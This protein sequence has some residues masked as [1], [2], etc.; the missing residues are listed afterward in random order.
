MK[1]HL[2]LGTLTV[3]LLAITIS[4]S[5]HKPFDFDSVAELAHKTA[6]E[7]SQVKLST[8]P[9]ILQSLDYD[10]YRDIRWQEDKTLWKEQGM[11]FQIKFFHPGHIYREKVNIY[12]LNSDG[13]QEYPY[14]ATNFNFGKNTF[15]TDFPPDTGY[16]GFRIHYP[17]NSDKYLDE[18]AVF[19]G[20]S[21]F[22]AVGKGQ[23]YGQ[24]ARG[25]AIDTGLANTIEEFPVFTKFW[26]SE[27]TPN[28]NEFTMYALLES[29][30]VT[31]AYQFKIRPDRETRMH[32]KARLYFRNEVK[33]LGIAPLTSM[34]WFAENSREK[35]GDFRPEVHDTDG[36]LMKT[37]TGEW[38]WRPLDN[39]KYLQENSFADNK[40]Q[41]FGL[42]Q[43]DRD[44]DHYKDL[45]ARYH[46][47]PSTWVE[48]IRGFD[49]GSVQLVQ[50]S[51]K[52]EFM[53]N[54]VAFWVPDHKPKAGETMEFEYY[55]DWFLT[56][57][58]RPGLGYCR[59]TG[60]DYQRTPD[61]IMFVL[62][63]AGGKL[64]SIPATEKLNEV[65][66]TRPAGLVQNAHVIKNEYS[67]SPSWRL[68]FE[69]VSPPEGREV[70]I[71]ANLFKG[72]DRLTE[73]WNYTWIP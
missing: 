35:P 25:L 27:P 44:F 67:S 72:N 33:R 48:P 9:T 69:V 10:Q 6:Q 41:G 14:Q 36:L 24:S 19:L 16:A 42:L 54:V 34:N 61:K 47:R 55:L 29:K 65:I 51:T 73:T 38:I 26:L 45:E 66:I 4:R 8:L 50:L 59:D 52:D 22:R 58:D 57:P 11:P 1:I 23:W 71:N 15:P 28:G 62:D 49:K 60:V 37:G 32:I 40:P 39:Q 13:A 20:A 31:G 63:F 5:V 64:D 18:A 3:L 17:L 56:N 12:T 43:R 21:Y 2:F 70:E 46:L 30:S 53:D 68:S 7:P